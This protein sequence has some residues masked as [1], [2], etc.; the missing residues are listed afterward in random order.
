MMDINSMAYYNYKTI[1]IGDAGVGKTSLVKRFVNNTKPGLYDITIGIDYESKLL[2]IKG[3]DDEQLKIKL[4]IWDTAGQEVFKSIINSY[5]NTTV[6]AIVV[7]DVTCRNSYN[8]V[9]SWVKEIRDRSR[10][11]TTIILVGNKCDLKSKRSVSTQEANEYAREKDIEY[12]ETSAMIDPFDKKYEICK[13]V[14]YIFHKLAQEIYNKYP[15]SY[16]NDEE[17]EAV[18]GIT[19]KDKPNVNNL[20]LDIY[21]NKKRCVCF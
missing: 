19:V 5:Y 1:L 2:E 13:S 20:H 4:Q 14:K 17:N 6:G 11:D 18:Q 9:N 3:E 15:C 8:H 16:I 7:F 10:S 21:N 12:I